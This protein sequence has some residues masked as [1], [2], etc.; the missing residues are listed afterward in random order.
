MK[1][2]QVL[3]INPTAEKAIVDIA[4]LAA[5][6]IVAV[7]TDVTATADPSP[8]APVVAT[9]VQTPIETARACFKNFQKAVATANRAGAAA[10]YAA[11][12]LGDAIKALK[13]IAPARRREAWIRDYIP[14]LSKTIIN[15]SVQIA[16]ARE[17]IEIELTGTAGQL[18]IRAALRFIRGEKTKVAAGANVAADN[19]S[20]ESTTDA[21]E[22]ETSAEKLEEKVD[23]SVKKILCLPDDNGTDGEIANAVR[24]VAKLLKIKKLSIND[25]EI[26]VI[27]RSE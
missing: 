10:I 6:P 8:A 13:Q 3:D 23:R 4:D 14:G 19:T 5:D 12:D 25:I 1:G 11:M 21:S 15:E 18:S 22:Q 17:R 24:T 20:P 16:D 26:K 2:L 27:N 9:Q 7:E